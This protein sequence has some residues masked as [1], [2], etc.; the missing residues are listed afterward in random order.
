MLLSLVITAAV[1]GYSAWSWRIAL[2]E[3]K[4]DLLAGEQTAA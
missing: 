3:R 1:V 2:A 4:R